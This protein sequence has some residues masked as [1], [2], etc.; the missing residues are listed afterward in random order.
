MH[1]Q[2][3]VRYGGERQ[4]YHTYVVEAEG[5]ANA[6][7]EAARQMPPE[8]SS[9]TDLVELRVAADPDTRSYLGEGEQEAV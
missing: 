3:T 9:E 2:I 1:Y 8:I 6:L 4:R 7:T 5:A